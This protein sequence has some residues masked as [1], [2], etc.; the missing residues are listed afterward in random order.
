MQI[1]REQLHFLNSDT[2]AN[3]ADQGKAPS[4]SRD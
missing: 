4:T 3:G 1:A 2:R